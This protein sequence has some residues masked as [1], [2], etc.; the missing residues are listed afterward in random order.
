MHIVMLSHADGIEN[1]PGL[2]YRIVFAI[3]TIDEILVR[4]SVL[5][6]S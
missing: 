3:A 6:L 4:A 2:N 5:N 1:V